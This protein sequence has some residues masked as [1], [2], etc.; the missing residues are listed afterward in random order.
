M[1]SYE[2]LD[3]LICIVMLYKDDQ[4]KNSLIITRTEVISRAGLSVS[5]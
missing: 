5:F 2:S 1:W 3:S 4:R